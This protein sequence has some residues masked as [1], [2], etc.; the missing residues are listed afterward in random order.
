VRPLQK[1][2][3]K[4]YERILVKTKVTKLEAYASACGHIRGTR[5]ARAA[6]VRPGA[7]AVGRTANGNTINAAAA[8]VAV[9]GAGSSP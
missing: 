2:I 1:R 8:G 7:V 5:R 4:R 3:E 6:G 9:D